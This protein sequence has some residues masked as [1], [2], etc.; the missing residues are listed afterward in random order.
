MPRFLKGLSVHKRARSAFTLIEVLV[1]VAIIA[2]LV[3][4]LL[5]SLAEARDQARCAKCLANLQDMGKGAQTFAAGHRFRFQALCDVNS[6][7]YALLN[8][9]SR[10][11]YAY[12][13]VPSPT[14]PNLLGW[15]LV[16]AREGGMRSLKKN[17]DWGVAGGGV[18]AMAQKDSVRKIDQLGCPAEKQGFNCFQFPGA[19]GFALGTNPSFY[20]GWLSYGVNTDINGVGPGIW[21]DGD[22]TA[23]EA[24]KGQ[25]DKVLRPSEVMLFVDSGLAEADAAASAGI[26]NASGVP[27]CIGTGG[28]SGQRPRGPLLEY[29]DAAY[30]K[31]LRPERHRR[32]SLNLAYAD[33][34]GGYVKRMLGNPVNPQTW[35]DS[36]GAY[37]LLPFWSYQPKARVSPYAS[38]SYPAPHP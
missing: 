29:V 16:L 24:L 25:L 6:P 27:T 8:D 33:G 17:S 18:V 4:I 26:I 11:L 35:E 3:A 10:S 31:K 22:K 38:G 1:V 19:P 34:H 20:W 13:S 9:S 2:L 37:P 30:H 28:P 36:S 23:G 5:P 12:E 7:S 21:K 32:S 15:P 14:V